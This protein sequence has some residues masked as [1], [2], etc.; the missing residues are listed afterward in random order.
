MICPTK[1]FFVFDVSD[2]LF[3]K[4][5]SLVLSKDFQLDF[6]QTS[7]RD[8]LAAVFSFSKAKSVSLVVCLGTLFCLKKKYNNLI[9][10]S[11]S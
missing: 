5:S 3:H 1:Q 8:I 4:L 6:S 11:D 2:G 9:L 7:D 10:P